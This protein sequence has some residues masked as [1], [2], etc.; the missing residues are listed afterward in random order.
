[1]RI[2]SLTKILAMPVI[3]ALV[4]LLYLEFSTDIST[5]FWI[6]APVFL[7]VIL[8]ISY[9]EIDHWYLQRN[10]IKLDDKLIHLLNNHVPYYRN[11]AEDQKD[12]YHTRLSQYITG[13]SYKSVG[14]ELKDVPYDIK[15][16]IATNA[17]Q[18]SFSQKDYLIGDFD[19]I[20]I[21]KHPFGTPKYQFLHTVETEAEDGMIIYSLEQLMPGITNPELYYNIG[22]HGMVEAF[23]KANPKAPFPPRLNADWF[24]IVAISG[25]SKKQILATIGFENVDLLVVLATCYFTYPEAFEKRLPALHKELDILFERSKI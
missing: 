19:R 25:L 9:E 23:I 12:K 13:R 16:M 10:P 5:G 7:I 22:M 11:L 15:A 3:F 1:M 6:L 8:Y 17:I 4:A 18:L 20:F 2:Y 14:S 24:D 21:Y